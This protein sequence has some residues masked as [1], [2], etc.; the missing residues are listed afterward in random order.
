MKLYSLGIPHEVDLDT[1]AGGHG[2]TY[3][4]AMA[5][6]AIRFLAERLEQ[7]RRRLT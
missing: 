2:F 4:N 3:Y 1:R 6:R 7:E 5:G